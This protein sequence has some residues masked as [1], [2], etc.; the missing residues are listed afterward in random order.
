M[1]RKLFAQVAIVRQASLN[2]VCKSKLPRL[3]HVAG[4]NAMQLRRQ[5]LQWRT[6]YPFLII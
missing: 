2:G 4:K 6:I 3:L 5:G 1:V